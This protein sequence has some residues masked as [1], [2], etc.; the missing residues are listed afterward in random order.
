MKC[1]TGTDMNRRYKGVPAT[2]YTE[3]AFP[4]WVDIPV[5]E[6]GLGRRLNEMNDWH[7]SHGMAVRHGRGGMDVVRFCFPDE[8]HAKALAR[9]FGALAHLN[10]SS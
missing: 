1:D 7:H 5:P 4:W 10:L 3:Q 6:G 9:Q 2:H 8:G